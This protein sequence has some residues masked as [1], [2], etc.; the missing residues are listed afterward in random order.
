MV[1]AVAGVFMLGQIIEGN[2]VSPILVGDRVGLH[3]VWLM[4]AVMAGGALFGFVGVLIAVPVA[5]AI[6]VLLRFALERYLESP[7]YRGTR[8]RH[9]ARRRARATPL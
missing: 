8:R 6:A 7:L 3:P 4:L 9:A 2:F 5:A 1:A